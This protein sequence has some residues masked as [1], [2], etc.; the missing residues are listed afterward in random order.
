M[1]DFEKFSVYIKAQE[2]FI[3][4]QPFF[5]KRS[6]TRSLRDQ[7]YRAF[8]SILLNIA[9]G[10]GKFSRPD[11]KNFYLIARGSAQ[12]CVSILKIL[13]LNKI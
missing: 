7:L 5:K 10:A 3:F 1:L 12:E 8:T 13:K 6:I 4:L 11:K 2:V 9:E